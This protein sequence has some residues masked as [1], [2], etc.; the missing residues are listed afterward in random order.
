MELSFLRELKCEQCQ[1]KFNKVETF[2]RHQKV[3]H[4]PDNQSKLTFQLKLRSH[5]NA[6]N[7]LPNENERTSNQENQM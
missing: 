2:E 5:V 7:D 1:R 4:K 3:D 6:R